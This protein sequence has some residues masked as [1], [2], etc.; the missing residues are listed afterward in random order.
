[1]RAKSA[2][3]VSLLFL[4]GCATQSKIPLPDIS[5]NIAGGA[6]PMR[7]NSSTPLS[8]DVTIRN[9]AEEPITLQR[10]VIDAHAAASYAVR[11]ENKSFNKIIEPGASET[12]HLWGTLMIGSIRQANMEPLTLRA[13]A[14]FRAPSGN[15]QRVLIQN[16]GTSAGSLR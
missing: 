15:F 16:L 5:L 3:L 6:A 11:T 2:V 14:H 1:M 9:M 8:F 7:S 13:I 12:V 10:V 4:V